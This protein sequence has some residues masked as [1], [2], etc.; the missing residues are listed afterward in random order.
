M[1]I[2]YAGM[3]ALVILLE[4]LPILAVLYWDHR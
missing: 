3:I 1:N 4:L 2:G